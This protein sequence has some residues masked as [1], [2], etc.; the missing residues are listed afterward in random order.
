MWKLSFS[1]LRDLYVSGWNE[2][3][4]TIF[5]LTSV[6][7]SFCM[8]LRVSMFRRERK[9][10]SFH[11]ILLQIF[12]DE[13]SFD[14]PNMKAFKIRVVY[15]RKNA[16]TIPSQMIL[17]ATLCENLVIKLHVIWY[18]SQLYSCVNTNFVS[19]VTKK[20][21]TSRNSIKLSISWHEF[22]LM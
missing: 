12:L 21:N 3:K 4:L 10:A 9:N 2:Y 16:T 18:V 19:A 22:L 14:F 6:W 5:V 13:I 15:I 7:L 8:C 17:L 11:A 1:V 20:K